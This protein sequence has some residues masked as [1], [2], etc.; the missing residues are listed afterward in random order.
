MKRTK[1]LQ[2]QRLE[3]RTTPAGAVALLTRGLPGTASATAGGESLVQPPNDVT[4]TGYQG[5]HRQGSDDGRFLA[6]TSSAANLVPGQIDT[7]AGEDVF[8]FDSLT[9]TTTLVSRSHDAPLR[10]A[11]GGGIG[12]AVSADGRFV[13]FQSAAS[14]FVPGYV[15][16]ESGGYDVYLFDRLNHSVT[17][18]SRDHAVPNRGANSHTY[19]LAL[20]ADGRY[21]TY[22]SPATNLIAGLQQVFG[23]SGPTPWGELYLFDRVTQSTELISHPPG[24]PTTTG[25]QGTGP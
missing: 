10:A 19:A 5:N 11:N 22:N 12:P 6:F 4:G 23:N 9:Q 7:N 16:G 25:E 3:S 21:V 20:S 17:L 1:N 13:A 24:L 2:L 15:S 18:V 8:L 14:D